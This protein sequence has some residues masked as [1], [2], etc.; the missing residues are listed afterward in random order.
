[1][2]M[3]MATIVMT[4]SL[5]TVYVGSGW[6]TNRVAVVGYAVRKIV[7]NCNFCV[8]R[9][10]NN[11]VNAVNYQINGSADNGKRFS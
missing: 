8:N 9:I 2:A 10:V 3:T 1:M 4:T 11:D 7:N 5:P 6:K